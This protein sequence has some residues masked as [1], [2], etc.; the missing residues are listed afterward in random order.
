MAGVEIPEQ[1]FGA[2]KEYVGPIHDWN[3]LWTFSGIKP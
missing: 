1:A 3:T 2:A